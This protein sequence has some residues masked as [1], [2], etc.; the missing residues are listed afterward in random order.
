MHHDR[1]YC[2]RPELGFCRTL[3]LHALPRASTT[4][5][6]TPI[7]RANR[8]AV[9]ISCR[10]PGRTR[11]RGATGVPPGSPHTAEAACAAAFSRAPSIA[12]RF[13]I[14][15]SIGWP[16]EPRFGVSRQERKH[17]CS[18]RIL[19]TTPAPVNEARSK[20]RKLCTVD[21]ICTTSPHFL[22]GSRE[23]H[24]GG[25]SRRGLCREQ[26]APDRCGVRSNGPIDGR[27]AD[28][29]TELSVRPQYASSGEDCVCQSLIS[30]SSNAR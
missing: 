17:T 19:P 5:E 3:D 24:P 2:Y 29:K 13:V 11:H 4:A 12:G 21:R 8:P 30:L 16:H 14:P 6:S 1:I 10:V 27:S 9:S 23:L 20:K 7:Q 26:F 28:T 18:I 25:T 22:G 15:P